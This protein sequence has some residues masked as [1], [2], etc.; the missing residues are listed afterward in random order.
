MDILQGLILGAVQGLTEFLPVSSSGHLVIFQHILNITENP[1]FFDTLV[2]LATFFSIILFFWKD[3]VGICKGIS[4]EIQEGK[5]GRNLKLLVLLIVG[6]IPAVAGGLLFKDKVESLFSNASYLW[7]FF[8]ITAT[9]LL[10]AQFFGKEKKDIENFSWLRGMGVGFFQLIAL[11]PGVSRSGSTSSGAALMG[12]KRSDGFLFS[13]L[14]GAIAIFG[15][16][17]LQIP[18]STVVLSDILPFSLGAVVAFGLGYLALKIFQRVYTKNNFIPFSIY[19][20]AISI[21][22]FILFK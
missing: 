20:V 6:S 21:L 11:L 9:L 13:F 16:A 4:K 19:C 22:C 12:L 10:L 14:L 17:V 7:I 15:A 18:Q 2:H 1:I 8:L 5:Y 3:I